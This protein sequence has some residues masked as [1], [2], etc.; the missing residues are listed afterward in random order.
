MTQGTATFAI[1]TGAA[2]V[3]KRTAFVR[4]FIEMIVAMFLGMGVFGGLAIAIF[5]AAGSSLTD[6]SVGLR[7]MLMS[8]YMTIP[9]VGWMRY[10]GHDWAGTTEMA[11]SM[12]VPSAIVAAVAWGGALGAGAALAIQHSIMIPAMLG[13]MLWRYEDYAHPHA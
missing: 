2:T 6:Q 11:A 5:A 4:H 7:V 8:V 9:M 10:R 12:I 3:S 1:A 13:V